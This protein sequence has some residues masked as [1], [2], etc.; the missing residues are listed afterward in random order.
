LTFDL[1]DMTWAQADQV[2][3]L[4]T[5]D[6]EWSGIAFHENEDGVERLIAVT[7]D[8]PRMAIFNL[9]GTSVQPVTLSGFSDVEGI[10]WMSGGQFAILEERRA[11]SPRYPEIGLVT[12]DVDAL[13]SSG[14]TVTKP[15]SP[16][17]LTSLADGNEGPEGIAYDEANEQFYIAKEISPMQMWTIDTDGSNLTNITSSFPS[18]TGVSDY[19][20]VFYSSPYLYVAS[21]EGGTS[22][23]AKVDMSTSPISVVD[24]V[25]GGDIP[26]ELE[27]IALTPN[28][29]TIFIV[30]DDGSPDYRSFC[31]Q[32]GDFD[33]SGCA[34]EHD[35]D[36]LF[37]AFG[38]TSAS[39]NYALYNVNGV[40]SAIDE[41]DRNYFV[42]RILETT[43]GD[44]NLDRKFDSSDLVLVLAAGEYED[45]TSNNSTWAEGDWDGDKD[46]TSSDNVV[47]FQ[48]GCYE[49]GIDCDPALSDFNP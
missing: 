26:A 9:D 6:D 10:T 32:I 33:S 19:S 4:L 47:A 37:A 35:L 20:D 1:D 23:I 43:Y 30:T 18:I 15:G 48:D 24:V 16:I 46:Y 7:N 5:G 44:A 45:A 27:G 28:R 29:S 22:D 39:Q 11:S 34:N 41:Y 49:E 21:E 25:S 36:E 2:T 12:I 42:H 31:K 8:T 38:M 40:G 14:G 17:T 3:S 13:A